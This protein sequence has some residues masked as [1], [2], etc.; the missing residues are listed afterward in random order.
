MQGPRRSFEEGFQPR[1]PDSSL[2]RRQCVAAPRAARLPSALSFIRFLSHEFLRAV[3]FLR[4]PPTSAA[5][6]ADTVTRPL[7]RSRNAPPPT[8]NTGAP[9]LADSGHPCQQGRSRRVPGPSNAPNCRARPP[10]KPTGGSAVAQAWHA[11]AP[12]HPGGG[13]G[14][15]AAPVSP[16]IPPPER[17]PE[18]PRL[19]AGAVRGLYLFPPRRYSRAG[20]ANIVCSSINP[21]LFTA[22]APS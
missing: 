1:R 20:A 6:R 21:P 8:A 22:A 11:S 10:R 18:R 4:T 2:L 15:F 7:A 14:A 13:N 5:G 12:G 3:R 17:R 16:S 9:I 19:A